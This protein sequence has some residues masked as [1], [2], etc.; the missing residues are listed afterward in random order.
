M[1][2]SHIRLIDMINSFETI[3]VIDLKENLYT[4]DS[5]D[6]SEVCSRTTS[7]T[8]NLG[9]DYS[10]KGLRDWLIHLFTMFCFVC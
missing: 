9:C 10:N 3:L 1:K 8:T 6:I 4:G 7:V 2:D 5:F